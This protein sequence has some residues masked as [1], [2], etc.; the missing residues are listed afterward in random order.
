MRKFLKNN[1]KRLI[2]FAF[3]LAVFMLWG[4][5]VRAQVTAGFTYNQ[6]CLDIQ[7]ID[8]SSATVGIIN[9]WNWDFGDGDI[10]TQ[11]SPLHTYPGDGTYTVTLTVTTDNFDTDTYSEDVFIMTP[12]AVFTFDQFCDSLEFTDASTP[13]AEITAWNW[14][15]G[16]GIGTSTLKD[17]TYTYTGPG[18]FTVS[19]TVT[20]GNGCTSLATTQIISV[21]PEAAFDYTQSCDFFTFTD[22][23]TPPGEITNWDWDFGDGG[24]STDQSPTY[25]YPLQGDYTVSL[26]VTNSTGC[27]DSTW[28]QVSIVPVAAFSYTQ[29]CSLFDFTDESTPLGEIT[30]YDWDFGDGIGFSNQQNPSYDYPNTGSYT[31]TLSVSHTS[32]CSNTTTQDILISKPDADFTF[33]QFCD[34]LN[35]TDLST[36]AA[37]IEFWDW[38]FGDGIGTSTDQNPV[39]TYPT[40]GDHVITLTITD[41]LGCSHNKQAFINTFPTE[42]GFE[43]DLGCLNQISVFTDTSTTTIIDGTWEIDGITFPYQPSI[44]YTFTTIGMHSVKLNVTNSINCSGEE[45]K[46]IEIFIP[47]IADFS[48]QSFCV[49]DTTIF[50]N[51]TDTQNVEVQS[52][53][54]NFNDPGSPDNTSPLYEPKH[55]FSTP[56]PFEVKLIVENVNGCIDSIV[57]TIIIDSLPEPGFS[58]QEY[59]SE[60]QLVTFIDESQAPGSFITNRHWDWGDGTAPGININPVTHTYNSGGAFTLCLGITDLNGCTDTLCEEIKIAKKPLADFTYT[61][62]GITAYFLDATVIDTLTGTEE[63]LWTF[64]NNLGT[65]NDTNPTF[66][67]PAEGFYDVNIMVTDSLGGIH[68]TTKNI[69]VGNSIIADYITDEDICHGDTSVIFDNSFSPVGDTILS[70]NWDFGDGHD[71]IYYE[72]ATVLK[73]FY[74]IGNYSLRLIITANNNGEE[75]IDSIIRNVFIH[76]NPIAYFDSVGVCKGDQSLFYDLSD[77]WDTL[78]NW[79]W[80]FGDGNI[81][82]LQD[83]I[84]L[85]ADTG[86]YAVSLVVTSQFGCKDT[87][88]G[89]SHVTYAPEVTFSVENAC[90]DSPAKFIP[91]YGS[92]TYVSDWEWDFG[93]PNNDT[94]STEETPTHIFTYFGLYN[95]TVTASS[96]GCPKTTDKTILVYPIP[97]SDF[98][99]TPDLSGSQ[100]KVKFDNGSIYA[101]NYLWDFGNGQTSTVENPIEVYEDDSTYLITLISYNEYGCSDTSWMEYELFFKGLYFPTAFSPNNPNS[102]VSLFTPAGVNLARY[103]VQVFDMRGN[104]V[105]ESEAIDDAGRPT[106]SWDGYYEGR[107]MPQGLYLWQATGTFTDGSVWKGTTLQDEEPQLH[108]TV[109]LIR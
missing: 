103:H 84:H 74:E 11:Q 91:L 14:D 109:T 104:Q 6:S 73:H 10:S 42:V 1:I 50:I 79:L 100:G 101:Q 54:W 59:S 88:L 93:D 9:A 8:G 34:S 4:Q 35:F 66:I 30:I 20:H 47:P 33:T 18:D 97:Y 108:G 21:V 41:S 70:W 105:W 39:Y 36:S 16:D 49:S 95:V 17:P 40:P 67:F 27:T 63:W 60:G 94:L 2:L 98:D 92:G 48:S 19:L 13:P 76:P 83:P 87:I 102:E 65:S 80:N 26:V 77:S 51:E 46:D 28:Q 72:K 37:G 31:V 81:S 25:T 68:D 43:Y 15:F 7:F 58:Y 53:L 55:S 69:Y 64:G 29:A 99:M 52:W 71:T 82:T 23:S 78:T 22:Q 57:N 45:Q 61:A 44:D 3:T 5:T 75:A 106:E 96:Y 62:G 89:H 38:N 85:Y 56:G 12:V 90:I 24:T 86:S 32:G 107:L